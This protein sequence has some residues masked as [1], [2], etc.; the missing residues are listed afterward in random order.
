MCVCVC[1]R[2]TLCTGAVR[3]ALH[4]ILFDENVHP[5]VVC[6]C[7]S[8][9]L[10]ARLGPYS[11]VDVCIICNHYCGKYLRIFRDNK[12]YCADEHGDGIWFIDVQYK[13]QFSS[14]R[15][16][17]QIVHSNK[18]VNEKKGNNSCESMKVESCTAL[19]PMYLIYHSKHPIIGHEWDRTSG[20]KIMKIPQ[21]NQVHGKKFHSP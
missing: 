6:N 8:C 17:T 4:E 14:G 20:N 9:S 5:I 13:K 11:N 1:S 18:I 7:L 10:A 19:Y 12:S 3:R 16:A 21:S 15:Q 2:N